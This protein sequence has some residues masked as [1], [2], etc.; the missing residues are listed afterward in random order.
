MLT[1]TADYSID[2]EGKSCRLDLSFDSNYIRSPNTSVNFEAV[3]KTLPL[4]II[5]K[6]EEYQTIKLIFGILG[7]I[8]VGIFA[9]SLGH[10]MIGAETITC[11]VLVYLSNVLY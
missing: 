6:Q 4:I 9:V 3:S 5:T 11:S 2:M 10:K 8:A 1:L 7:Y